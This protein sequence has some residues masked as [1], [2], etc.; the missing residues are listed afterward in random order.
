MSEDQTVAAFDSAGGVNTDERE[1]MLGA[2][3][4]NQFFGDF[5]SEIRTGVTG[6]L[7]VNTVGEEEEEQSSGHPDS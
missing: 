2:E 7:V 5:G 1:A 6:K 4:A 3:E